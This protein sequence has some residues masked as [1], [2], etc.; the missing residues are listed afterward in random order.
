MFHWILTQIDGNRLSTVFNL[1]LLEGNDPW[2]L[3]Q[4]YA[5]AAQR[6]NIE[7]PLVHLAA[8]ESIFAFVMSESFGTRKIVL[9]TALLDKLTED[10]IEALV[11]ATLAYCQKTNHFLFS[12]CFIF[13]Q[14]L[15]QI[16][17]KLD[18]LIPSQKK[19]ASP[20]IFL[21]RPI[22]EFIQRIG[23]PR[24]SYFEIDESS[25]RDNSHQMALARA[26]WKMHHSCTIKPLK[27][28]DCHE[29]FFLVSPVGFVRTS[30]WVRC[31]PRIE[32]RVK[33]LVG[34]FPI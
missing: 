32:S 17:A 20:T 21:L 6:L 5:A 34:T 27:I 7:R 8:H 1:R 11:A 14:I 31:H 12:V 22:I 9:S 29:I 2:R 19:F 15:I 26:L 3:N 16:A 13:S 33:K 25:S 30:R 24:D 28:P 10:E 4:K 23:M 18:S